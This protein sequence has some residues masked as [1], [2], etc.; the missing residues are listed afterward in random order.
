[1]QWISV[2]TTAL[3]TLSHFHYEGHIFSEDPRLTGLKPRPWAPLPAAPWPWH[4]LVV[5]I[6][7]GCVLV[8][9][10]EGGIQQPSRAE[11]AGGTWPLWVFCPQG[12]LWGRVEIRLP[13]C[14]LGFTLGYADKAVWL[15]SVNEYLLVGIIICFVPVVFIHVGKWYFWGVYTQWFLRALSFLSAWHMKASPLNEVDGLENFPVWL[16]VA[17]VN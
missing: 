10:G 1:M 15:E 7:I 6:D 4:S 12:D 13:S 11:P 8:R 14:Y 3:L 5:C 2:L 16:S 17:N 9:D